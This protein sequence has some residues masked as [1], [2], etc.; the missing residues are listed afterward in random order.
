MFT[1]NVLTNASCI[2]A[3]LVASLLWCTYVGLART[4]YAY[5]IFGR[6]FTKY[7]VIYG[8]YV[9]FCPTLHI[10]PA[11]PSSQFSRRNGFAPAAATGKPLSL[12]GSLGERAIFVHYD[13]LAN[14]VSHPST[15][16]K[17]FAWFG[18]H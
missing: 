3:V 14:V 18:T 9:W 2:A 15:F 12:H 4:I 11:C 8:V 1:L 16:A 6:E 10:R 7:T 17:S 5:N 13:F